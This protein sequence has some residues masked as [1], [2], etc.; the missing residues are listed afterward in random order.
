MLDE[1]A[2]DGGRSFS[3]VLHITWH[4]WRYRRAARGRANFLRSTVVVRPHSP[5]RRVYERAIDTTIPP[6]YGR[7]VIHTLLATDMSRASV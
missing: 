7:S 4:R 2:P 3:G 5:L 6:A 1:R